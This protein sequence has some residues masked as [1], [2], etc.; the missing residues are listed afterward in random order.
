MVD[1]VQMKRSSGSILKP[2]LYA[3]AMDEGLIVPESVLPDIPTS[4]GLYSP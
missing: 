2:F 4:Y 3:L 1:G